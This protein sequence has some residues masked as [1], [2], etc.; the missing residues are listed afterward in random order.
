MM[1]DDDQYHMQ[2]TPRSLL[3]RDH[4]AHELTPTLVLS[5]MVA[6]FMDRCF[7]CDIINERIRS[8][9]CLIR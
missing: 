5:C 9:G 7:S 4:A 6:S 1:L 8:M 2:M 3:H